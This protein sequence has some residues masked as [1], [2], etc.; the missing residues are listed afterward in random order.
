MNRSPS[1][2][3]STPPSPRTPSVIRVPR[4]LGGQTMPVGWNWT[5]SM[6][7]RS[8]PAQRA[9]AWPSAV[10]SHEFE[11]IVPASADPARGQHHGLGPEQDEPARLPPVA[12]AAGDP[13]AVLEERAEGAFHEDVDALVD[14][15]VL[16][17]ADHLQAG[18][19]AD[20]G[21]PGIGVSA[22]VALEDAA[23]LGAVEDRPP[24]LQLADPVGRLLGVQLGHPPLVE[25]LAPAHRVA[26]VDLPAI[27]GVGAGQGGRD[28]ALGHDR[29]GLAQERLADQGRLRPPRGGLD[30]GP[31]PRPAG[32]D[33]HDVVIVLFVFIH[34]LR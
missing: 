3:L 16:E 7:I 24:F 11:L 21:E 30:R 9:M 23:L 14:A 34:G 18:P 26:E 2:F 6:S 31:E 28:P 25:E 15:A 4:T 5:N 10:Y 33:D 19:V 22:E 13:V 12:E 1:L 27:A 32:A 8:A 29:V 17:R 20:V